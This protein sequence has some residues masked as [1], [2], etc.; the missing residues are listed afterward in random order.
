MNQIIHINLA[1]KRS[2]GM[3]TMANC[4]PH[5]NSV[6]RQ[7]FCRMTDIMEVTITKRFFLILTV[8]LLCVCLPAWAEE[9]GE[10]PV[11]G[12]VSEESEA[13]SP[14]DDDPFIDDQPSE[15][16]APTDSDGSDQEPDEEV[17]DEPDL[18]SEY[19]EEEAAEIQPS[20]G[21]TADH[22]TWEVLHDA[23][24]ISIGDPNGHYTKRTYDLYCSDCQQVV[25]ENYRTEEIYEPHAL[26]VQSRTMPTCAAPGEE[27]LYCVQCGDTVV[28]VLPVT[29]HTWEPWE[30]ASGSRHCVVCGLEEIRDIPAPPADEPQDEAEPQQHNDSH[31]VREVLHDQPWYESLGSQDRHKVIRQY[32]LVCLDCNQVIEAACRV[33]ETT[34]PHSFQLVSRTDPTCVQEGQEEMHCPLCGDDYI[35][36]LPITDHQWTE[37][38]DLDE[39]T[40]DTCIS[41]RLVKRR[42]IICGLEETTLLP[43][44][45]HQWVAVSYTEATCDEDGEAVRR[46]AVCGLEETLVLPA[47]GHTYV[48]NDGQL[49]CAI[50]GEVKE[51]ETVQAQSKQ[52]HMYYNNTVTSFGPTTRELIGGSVWNRVTPVDLSQEGVFTYPLIASNQ[53][54]VGTATLVNGQDSQEVQY[55][56]S[57]SKINV[58]SESLVVYPDLEALKTGNHAISFDFN[59]P[60]D[61]K[62]RFGEDAHVIV[63][64]T[65]KAD[66]DADSVGIRRFSADQ[67]WIDQMMEMIK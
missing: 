30:E 62:A 36:V 66:Y 58:H 3:I 27:T 50:C 53:Y 29:E 31:E 63:A 28:N 21:H 32:D 45:G 14:N 56:L 7:L 59:E 55:K 33:E 17:E 40:G 12:T 20:A 38:E 11:A 5:R 22:Q 26:A 2:Y 47:Y 13:L 52:S 9:T 67:K 41:D 46:C 1:D 10:E 60:I 37:W 39:L 24:V 49:T 43:A 57:S 64:I 23:S 16:L 19:E 18:P 6:P 34:E 65:L 51:K 44:S 42:C 54:T 35:S 61:L 4:L 8:L 48:Q 25:Q 15:A